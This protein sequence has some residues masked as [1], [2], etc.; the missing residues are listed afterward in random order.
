MPNR[1][2]DPERS[3]AGYPIA[4]PG[5]QELFERLCERYPNL[6]VESIQRILRLPPVA[7]ARRGAGSREK[8]TER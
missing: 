4:V 7:K 2:E 3:E 8:A 5:L 6:S 1:L